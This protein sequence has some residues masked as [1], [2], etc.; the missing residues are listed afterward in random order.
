MEIG[1]KSDP[2]NSSDIDLFYKSLYFVMV[3]S[4]QNNYIRRSWITVT[5][6]LHFLQVE[7]NQW[8]VNV[9]KRMKMNTSREKTTANLWSRIGPIRM[10]LRFKM[11][12]YRVCFSTN[13]PKNRRISSFLDNQHLPS[14]ACDSK[15][16]ST[17][18]RW[19]LL[20]S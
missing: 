10:S 18:G 20:Y 6:G 9:N 1:K 16:Y 12:Y 14:F 15:S 4:T 2:Y 11:T 8:K 17:F 5:G 19:F 13:L 3:L 7:N